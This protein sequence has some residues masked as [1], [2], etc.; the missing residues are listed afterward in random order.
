MIYV[1]D[2]EAAKGILDKIDDVKAKGYEV[3]DLR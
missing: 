1:I 3:V 2:E